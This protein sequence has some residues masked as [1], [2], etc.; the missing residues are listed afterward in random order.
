MPEKADQAQHT[1]PLRRPFGMRDLWRIGCWGFAAA[2]ALALAV[3]AS[4]TDGS[5]ER[6]ALALAQWRGIAQPTSV[7]SSRPFDDK[8]A[9]RLAEAVRLLT[10]DRDRLLTRIATLEHSVDDITG[11]IA[12]GAN[13]AAAPMPKPSPMVPPIAAVPS[14]QTTPPDAVIR[15]EFGI[16]IGSAA[17]VEGLRALWATAKARHATMLEG[18]RPI[19][20]VREHAR[21]GGVELRLVAGPIPNAATAARLCAALNAGGAVCQPALFDGQ[22]LAVR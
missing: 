8:E 6:L 22:R 5:N 16:D 21:P 20:S 19:M 13:V 1:A 18:L 7:A 3:L 14:T 12:R 9:R 15:T 17:T 2:G 10:A 4:S 11:S